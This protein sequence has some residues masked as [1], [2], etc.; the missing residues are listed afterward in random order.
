MAKKLVTVVETPGFVQDAK[1]VLSEKE[2]SALVDLL[3][4]NPEAGSVLV[5]GSGIRKVRVGAKGKGKSGG[6]RVIYYFH[7]DRIP[8]YLLA[9]FAKNE[10]DNLSSTEKAALAGIAKLIKEAHNV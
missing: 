8:V 9:L 5:G 10:K 1:G 4:S 6:A 7:D 2:V 3:A